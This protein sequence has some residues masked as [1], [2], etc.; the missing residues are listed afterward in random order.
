MNRTKILTPVLKSSGQHL[1][2]ITYLLICFIVSTPFNFVNFQLLFMPD[3]I[4]SGA[5]NAWHTYAA[6]KI[7][8]SQNPLVSYSQFPAYI[9]PDNPN[10]YPSFLHLTV[11]TITNVVAMMQASTINPALVIAAEKTFM[12]VASLAGTAGY[13]LLIK[14]LLHKSIAN[15]VRANMDTVLT[16]SRIQLLHLIVCVASF[17]IFIFSVSPV[18]QT[19]SDGTYAQ[20]FGMWTI[21]PFYMYFLVNKRWILSGFLLSLIASTHNLAILMSLSATIPFLLSLAIQRLISKKNVLLFSLTFLGCA[22]PAFIFFYIPP[23]ITLLE[24]QSTGDTPRGL[25]GQLPISSVVQQIKPVLFYGGISATSLLLIMNLRRFAWIF[26]WV[27]I[28]FVV[29]ELTTVIGARFARELGVVFGIVVGIC[30]G[31]ALY[32]M[33]VSGRNW[34]MLF[35]PPPLGDIRVTPAKLVLAVII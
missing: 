12:F 18:N 21:F 6:L 23:A 15:K 14:A 24:S 13:G 1:F 7:I 16:G 34:Y 25:I 27:A 29:F 26:G 8:T 35:R 33:I 32:L 22:I 20:L 30:V 3:G 19:Y 17:S 31:Y 28:Y 9:H 10:Y 4:P 2:T 5:D 11:A